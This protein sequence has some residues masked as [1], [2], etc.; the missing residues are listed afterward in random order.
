MTLVIGIYWVSVCMAIQRMGSKMQL[1]V[2]TVTLCLVSI[3][4]YTTIRKKDRKEKNRK[5]GKKEK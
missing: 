3:A 2:L 1:R 4:Y 5:E